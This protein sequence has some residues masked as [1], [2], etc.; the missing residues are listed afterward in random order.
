VN[1]QQSGAAFSARHFLFDFDGTLVDS[2]P[3]WARAMRSL[4]EKHGIP[5]GEDFIHIIT[6]LGREGTIA[7]L[8]S[9]GVKG[10]KEEL[11]RETDDLLRP[12]YEDVIPLKKGVRECLEALRQKGAG[13][14][15][16]TASPH[17]WMDPCLKRNGVW[18]LFDHV[19][20]CEDFGMIKTD[21]A[22]YLRA[23]ER[24]GCGR[25]DIAFLDDNI[26]ADRA[27]RESGVYVIGVYDES[28]STD[29]AA[30]RALADAYITDF[31]ELRISAA[32]SR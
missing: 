3:Y 11:L 31:D 13:L 28:S 26:N 30:M 29:E 22:I 17:R 1:T 10:T 16:L 27:A 24:I 5:C 23:A 6:P 9:I 8:S 15:I 2:M 18:E 19:W 7:Y 4:P 21:P 32:G 14:H 20:S 12:L 25:R